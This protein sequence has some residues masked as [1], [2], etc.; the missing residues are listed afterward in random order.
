MIRYLAPILVVLFFTTPAQ[1]QISWRLEL[2]WGGEWS[3][4]TDPT[5][6]LVNPLSVI[7][8]TGIPA[9]GDFIEIIARD[10]D[11]LVRLVTHPTD[12]PYYGVASYMLAARNA[13]LVKGGNRIPGN[14]RRALS[15]WYSDELLD[16]IR[17][18]TEWNV[19][20]NMPELLQFT[21][22]PS[23]RA[24]TFMNVIIF[25]NP[26]EVSDVTL[27]AHELY[28]ARQYHEWGLVEFARQWTNNSQESGPVEGPAYEQ[29]AMIGQALTTAGAPFRVNVPT[30]SQC[31]EVNRSLAYC[32]LYAAHG[33][34]A[35]QFRVQGVARATSNGTNSG[36]MRL[37][38][39]AN[40]AT[41]NAGARE[42]AGVDNATQLEGAGYECTI[43]VLAGQSRRVTL[44]APNSRADSSFTRAS[45][46]FIPGPPQTGSSCTVV[47]ASASRCVLGVPAQLVDATFTVTGDALA[48][49]NGTRSGRMQLN[50]SVDGVNCNSRAGQVVMVDN[51]TQLTGEGYSCTI[52]VLGG[53]TRQIEINAP[54]DRADSSYTRATVTFVPGRQR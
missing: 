5:T 16:S 34:P 14:V 33:G 2:P 18:S 21:G 53:T 38:M 6:L 19:V 35:A 45:A 9:T 26:D 13:V 3:G 29:E 47:S 37:V 36:R 46:T 30:S 39:L 48:T 23:I 25:R 42:D 7:N 40:E 32:D 31:F 17:W 44:S 1:A 50:L 20:Q 28:H 11:Q 8:P 15:P 12:A 4:S 24:I 52:V 22:K 54:N 43:I 27:W 49:S 51:A 41:C 10:P